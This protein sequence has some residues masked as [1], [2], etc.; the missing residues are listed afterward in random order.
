[1]YWLIIITLSVAGFWVKRRPPIE[2]EAHAIDGDSLTIGGVEMRLKGIDAP[3][4]R[5][6]CLRGGGSWAC[7]EEARRH[8]M[9]LAA[10]GRLSCTDHGAD[11]HGRRLATCF[12]DGVNLNEAMVRDGYAVAYGAYETAEAEARAAKRGLWS[13][14]FERPRAW[15]DRHPR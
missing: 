1:L 14:T 4:G 10:M 7:G 2:G 13:G 12:A 5:Q 3:E 6:T 8:L 15:R 11:Q 9:R